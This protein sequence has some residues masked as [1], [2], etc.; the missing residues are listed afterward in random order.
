MVS[1][2]H[3]LKEDVHRVQNKDYHVLASSSYSNRSRGVLIIS[4]RKLDVTILGS[5][6][7]SEGRITFLKT[8]T[9]NIKIAFVSIYAP[10]CFDANFCRELTQL[11]LDLPEFRLVIGSDFNAVRDHLVDR[12]NA[13]EGND[14]R[15]ATT[16]LK[17]CSEEVAVIDLWHLHNPLAR[18]FSFFSA[19]HHSFSR[20]DFIF[21]SKGLFVKV[22]MNMTPLS[23]SD[24]KAV[25]CR[26]NLSA[27]RKRAPRWRFN[28]FLLQNENFIGQFK[29]SLEEFI[30]IN[31]DSVDDPRVVWEAVK[32]FIRGKCTSLASNL[33]KS[34]HYRH[35]ELEHK[36]TQVEQTMLINTSPGLRLERSAICS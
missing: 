12:S 4:P 3:L 1:E 5:G 8:I 6:G 21:T 7:D 29:S 15:L 30:S 11:L 16:A 23:I 36:L 20:I 32:G 34:R 22:Y 24:H 18:E 27:H 17:K 13:T 9:S 33:N 31:R 25:I 28:T 26:A 10:N 35:L 2:T 14:Q 19:R